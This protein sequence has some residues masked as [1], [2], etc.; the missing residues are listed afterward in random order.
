[1]D[2]SNIQPNVSPFKSISNQDKKKILEDTNIKHTESVTGHWLKLFKDFLSENSYGEIDEIST[3]DL[4]SIQE[5]Q[6]K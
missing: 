5:E 4:P 1:M 6:G 2:V 3:E